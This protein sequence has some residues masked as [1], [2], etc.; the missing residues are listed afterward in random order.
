MVLCPSRLTVF[1]RIF[2]KNLPGFQYFTA[3]QVSLVSTPSSN[4]WTIPLITGDCMIEISGLCGCQCSACCIHF[5]KTSVRTSFFPTW[6]NSVIVSSKGIENLSKQLANI[7]I[8]DIIFKAQ[9]ILR[10]YDVVL[11]L[12]TCEVQF[13]LRFISFRSFNESP[14]SIQIFLSLPPCC[15]NINRLISLKKSLLTLSIFDLCC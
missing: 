14:A 7:V 11:T 6:G 1:S 2:L 15:F 12:C 13:I 3:D 4:G 8:R 5:K 10:S 9:Y